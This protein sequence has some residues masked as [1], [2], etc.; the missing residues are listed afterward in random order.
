VLS[1]SVKLDCNAQRELESGDIPYAYSFSVQL[2]LKK[3]GLSYW[4][5]NSL[6]NGR[7]Y[8]HLVL[9]CTLASLRQ[10]RLRYQMD[11]Q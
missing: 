4:W 8:F 3:D 7:F 1:H 11:L 2:I 9:R 5:L 10:K 6:D